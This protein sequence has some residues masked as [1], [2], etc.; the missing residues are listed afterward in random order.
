MDLYSLNRVQSTFILETAAMGRSS[1]A[2]ADENRLRILTAAGALFRARGVEDVGIADVMKAAGMTQGGFYNHFSSKEAITT[3][4]C[5]QSFDGAAQKWR[6]I[7]ANAR[8]KGK[9]AVLAIENY[10]AADKPP[11][12]TCPM[13]AFAPISSRRAGDDPLRLAFDDGVKALFAVYSEQAGGESASLSDAF[14]AMVG[15]KLLGLKLFGSARSP[16]PIGHSQAS[17]RR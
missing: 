1:R 8:D 15:A 13:I 17:R 2:Q 10:Y 16:A 14:A 7:A 9:D 6:E 3:E 11:E 12:A 4:A 5:T